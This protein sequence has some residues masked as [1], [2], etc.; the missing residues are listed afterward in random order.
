[1]YKKDFLLHK[2]IITDF[3]KVRASDASGYV[4]FDQFL[5]Y[6][7]VFIVYSIVHCSNLRNLGTII[8]GNFIV[9]DCRLKDHFG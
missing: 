5:S 9:F 6:L 1:M 7:F 4:N 3:G 8:Y 2:Y